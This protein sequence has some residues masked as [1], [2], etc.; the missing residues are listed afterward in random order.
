L[1][2]LITGGQQISETAGFS[3]GN[4]RKAKPGKAIGSNN[5]PTILQLPKSDSAKTALV[6][7]GNWAPTLSNTPFRA[8]DNIN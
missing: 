6:G 7:A 4:R 2:F 1:V 3:L 5:S 8:G